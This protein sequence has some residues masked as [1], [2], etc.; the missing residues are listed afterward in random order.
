MCDLFLDERVKHIVGYIIY[1]DS[2]E[3]WEGLIVPNIKPDFA[4][5]FFNSVFAD[6]IHPTICKYQDIRKKFVTLFIAAES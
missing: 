3:G 2:G 1:Q 6:L 4:S 5:S